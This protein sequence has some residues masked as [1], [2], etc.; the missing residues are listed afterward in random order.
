MAKIL[1]VDDRRDN[2][3][4][5]TVKLKEDNYEIITETRAEEALKK[6]EEE[7]PDCILLDVNMPEMD[8]FEIC[9]R[10]KQNPKTQ[11]IPV[12]FTTAIYQDTENIVKGLEVGGDDYIVSP[13]EAQELK[14]RVKV[15][16]RL[17]KSRDELKEKNLELELANEKLRERNKDLIR[18]N[19]FLSSIM[20]RK[21]I[22]L[23]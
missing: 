19:N 6:A 10:L 4:S 18:A 9:R 13:F 8:G 21:P 12:L 16:V 5:A 2:I 15:L 7:L 14:A 3:F 11:D 1:I 20:E 23:P 22:P 17:K